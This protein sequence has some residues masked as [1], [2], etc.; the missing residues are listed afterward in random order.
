VVLK[1]LER[2]AKLTKSDVDDAVIETVQKLGWPFYAFIS[3]Y[4]ALL[5]LTFPE[6]VNKWIHYIFL[7]IIT[8]YLLILIQ[9]AVRFTTKKI[10]KRMGNED[11]S[12]LKFL[13][14]LIVAV[15]WV[16]GFLLILSNL[17]F[18]I[19][20]LI[21]GL[22]IGG[23]AIALALQSILSDIFAS[24]SIYFD[25]PFKEGDFII[26]GEYM[27]VV[28]RIGIKTTRLESLWG[29]EIVISNQELTSTRVKNYKKME[30]RR[31]QFKFGLVYQTTNE[32]LKKVPK[33]VADIFKKIDIAQLDRVHFKEFGDSSLNFEVAY[34]V[35]SK[36]YND[37]MDVQQE[38]N[39]QL[40]ERLEKAGMEFAYPTQTIFINK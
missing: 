19:T 8:F 36:E 38:V 40:K 29:E 9:K 23:V 25:K 16:I 6:A 21:A 32:Q 4:L 10:V 17:G 35:G 5:F 26:V 11:V 34:Y 14:N 37:Y 2:L 28:K 20:S 24:V 22:G 30:R 18:N 7:I 12:I 31:I 39:L 27:G 33:I 3:I 15:L 1:K 13:S